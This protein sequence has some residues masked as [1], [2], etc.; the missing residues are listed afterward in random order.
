MRLSRMPVPHPLNTRS[1][2]ATLVLAGTASVA[3]LAG[4]AEATTTS[5][6]TVTGTVDVVVVDRHTTHADAERGHEVVLGGNRP[7]LE[8]T[9]MV[10]AGGRTYAVPAA[11]GN[12]LRSGQRVKVTLRSTR[13]RY[14]TG[15]GSG[16][17]T[18]VT[19]V[20]PASSIRA[21]AAAT[22]LRAAAGAHTLTVLPVYWSSPD[23]QT[24]ASL[25][26]LAQRTADYWRAQSQ[27]T[28]AITPTVRNWAKITDPGSCDSGAL[29]DR[30]L[31][32]H[33]VA[34]PTSLTSHVLVY[35]PQRS[36]CGGWAGLGSVSGSRIWVNGYPLLDVTAHEFGHNL[37]LG[38]A[39]RA[40]CTSGGSRVSLSTSCTVES[41][42]DSADVMGFATYAASGS[43][44]TALAD[45]IGLAQ[46]VTASATSPAEVELSP[47]TQVGNVR[48]VK[49]DVGTGWVYV[50]FRPAQAPDTR[51]PEWAGVQVHYLPNGSYP[52]SQLLDLQPWQS[53]AFT[54]TAMPAYSVWR[55]PG[56]TVAISVGVVGSTA[57]V[58]VVSTAADTSAPT[59]PSVQATRASSTTAT[60]IWTAST[61]AGSGVAG[62]RVNVD[63]KPVAFAGPTATSA[64]V[65]ASSSASSVRVDAVDAAGNVATGTAVSL[66]AGSTGSG[67]DTGSG[68]SGAPDAPV[69]TGPADGSAAASKTVTFAW[70][71]AQTGGA[72]SA[73]RLYA[74]GSPFTGLIPA[75]VRTARIVLPAATTTTLGVMALDST[76]RSSALA[77]ARVTVDTVAPAVPRTVKLAAGANRVTWTAPP[78]SGTALHYEVTLDGAPAVTTTETR[79]AVAAAGT[80]VWTVRTV[81]AAGNRSAPVKATGTVDVSAPGAPSLL[82]MTVAGQQQAISS[83]RAVVLS[84]L[85]AAEPDTWIATYR[86]EISAPSLAGP[87]VKTLSGKVLKASVTLPEG[88]STITVT[89]INAGGTVGEA[90]TA[91][92]QVDTTKP[93]AP[94]IT[95]PARQKAGAA[96]PVSWTAAGDE[97]SGILRYDIAVA[98]KVLASVASSATTATLPAGTFAAGRTARITVTAVN[99]AGLSNAGTSPVITVYAG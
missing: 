81:D 96:T 56:T 45:Q 73:Y 60:A 67:G 71:P 94:V 52:Q 99:G 47:L 66:A 9:T 80:H 24:Q 39:N 49:V 21:A 95:T 6:S 26:T 17:T 29:F 58:R 97:Q 4:P 11:L 19:A 3:G 77:T 22:S 16:T 85:A 98:G 79:S 69:I 63:G 65:S 37:G 28:V 74:N 91:T 40:T 64:Q 68:S 25:T 8:T 14:A 51:K 50:D 12:G 18:T 48:A 55:V 23:S 90:A 41:Y 34:A 31:A 89:A 30:A 93:S 88:T 75:A 78:D 33:Q 10:T 2:I 35:F 57:K 44:N 54:S 1:L 15:T 83:K 5:T 72:V 82:S 7:A 62:Y 46:T 70:S 53:S 32:A 59:V 36:D 86:L 27:G 13:L 76:G 84:W 92:M 42:Q 20:A 43:L 61:D 87:V 38:H